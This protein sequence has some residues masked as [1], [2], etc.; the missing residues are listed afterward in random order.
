MKKVGIF[1][2]SGTGNTEHVAFM[3]RNEFVDQGYQVDLYRMEDI[4]NQQ[5]EILYD[6]YD[7]IGI[8]AQVIGY[9]A[10]LLLT[11]FVKYM[12]K[13]QGIRAF[14][15]RTAG[16]VAP[17][18]YNA[19]NRIINRLK[20]KGYK[21][22]YERLFSIGSNWVV[23]FDDNVMR[24]L[25]QATQFKVK[26]MCQE[27]IDGKS[28]RLESNLTLKVLMTIGIPLFAFLLKII[29]K[30]LSVNSNCNHC[31]ICIHNCPAQNIYQKSDE[32][33]FKFK[34]NNCLRCVY[35]C[36]QKAIQYR[37]FKFF[38]I[39]SG[40]N[41]NHILSETPQPLEAEISKPPFFYK[42]YIEND[43]L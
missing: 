13:T 15:F 40:Y 23:K 10:P 35:A 25:Y 28:R 22:D 33:K 34:C 6:Q 26:L 3:I 43:D 8:G 37:I 24:S 39:P 2:F 38:V 9:G 29:G 14:V 21:I 32:V 42:A 11:R 18:N 30:D 5:I 27:L 16:G 19:S 17:I 31:G 36:P 41:I 1:Y 7:L 4:L 20:H 12:P